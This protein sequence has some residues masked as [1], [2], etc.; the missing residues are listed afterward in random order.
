VLNGDFQFDLSA[1]G[2]RH[3]S[4]WLI[5]APTNTTY[6]STFTVQGFT[7]TAAGLWTNGSYAFSETTGTLTALPEPASLATLALAALGLTRRPRRR[8]TTRW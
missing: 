5:V 2:T 3:G 7:E 1:A 4:A 8:R 6:G